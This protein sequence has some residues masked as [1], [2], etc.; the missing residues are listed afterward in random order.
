[1]LRIIALWHAMVRFHLGSCTFA[2]PSSAFLLPCGCSR[3]AAGISLHLNQSFLLC[4]AWLSCTRVP[5]DPIA[6]FDRLS[7]RSQQAMADVDA[8][9][10]QAMGPVNLV[11]NNEIW[12]RKQ[13][14]DKLS[15]FPNKSTTVESS[16]AATTL[17]LT[18][19]FTRTSGSS[20]SNSS[21]SSGQSS[22]A[23][24]DIMFLVFELIKGGKQTVEV[25]IGEIQSKRYG[26]LAQARHAVIREL[27]LSNSD[28]SERTLDRG[29]LL[30]GVSA[31]SS[32]ADGDINL[33]LIEDM[34]ELLAVEEI[35]RRLSSVSS[36][37]SVL[38][39]ALSVAIRERRKQ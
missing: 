13:E 29:E 22:V 1:M 32:L 11:M 14:A 18:V 36:C 30:E 28:G 33:Q 26:D 4:D 19:K 39:I 38:M 25:L 5:S 3:A 24:D 10:S 35:L 6:W 8:A 7:L 23:E 9:I 31:T 27:R 12:A 34:Q 20:A 2:A 17:R 15:R 37:L 16:A 21:V